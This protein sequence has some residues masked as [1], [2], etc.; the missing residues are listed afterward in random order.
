MAT[1]DED[2]LSLADL[3]EAETIDEQ[4][5]QQRPERSAPTAHQRPGS[6]AWFIG[7]LH[8]FYTPPSEAFEA[9]LDRVRNRLERRGALP[10]RSGPPSLARQAPPTAS[11]IPQPS[12]QHR[13]DGRHGW[14]A[15]LA[16]LVA[17]ALLVVLV[18]SLTIGL[19]L[20]HHTQNGTASTPVNR[21]TPSSSHPSPTATP[22]SPPVPAGALPLTQIQMVDATTGWAEAPVVKSW[23]ILRTTDGGVHWTDV[24]PPTLPTIEMPMP[25]F[26]LNASVAWVAAMENDSTQV[27]FRT[28]DGG[29]TWQRGGTTT[30][31]QTIEQTQ[32]NFINAQD[33]WF[34]TDAGAGGASPLSEAVDVFRTTDGGVTWTRTSSA[35]PTQ[36]APHPL[37]NDGV[38]TGLSFLNASTGWATGGSVN[39]T[40][41]IWFY[42]THDG[43]Y[44]WQAQTLALPPGVTSAQ[45]FWSEPPTFVSAQDGILP[46]VFDTGKAIDLAVY[47]TH[48]GGASWQSAPPVTVGNTVW[49]D[50]RTCFTSVTQG[51][52][53]DD[54]ALFATNDGGQ[55]WT[56]LPSNPYFG[57]IESLNFV[58]NTTGWLL[59]QTTSG[60]LVLLK[61]GDGG[62]TWKVMDP[63]HT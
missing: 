26:F 36:A 15:R 53:A 45:F 8:D 1:H 18:G 29:Q 39:N 58:S 25:A 34:L 27:F 21:S 4:I 12:R 13:Q 24:S 30:R 35:E 42:V 56:Q 59:S 10:R 9:R 3:A 61:T 48:D 37:P 28:T 54:A 41:M 43:G 19:S 44:T 60:A 16:T 51:W 62:Q 57:T 2:P 20:V 63:T 40:S 49:Q 47:V 31:I 52:A 17:V 33:G 38:K 50:V 14:S 22:T 46:V 6:D 11:P 7:E 23:R 5:D 55:H 32:M